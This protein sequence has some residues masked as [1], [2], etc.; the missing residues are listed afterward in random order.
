MQSLPG[1]GRSLAA[2]R[3]HDQQRGGGP[4]AFPAPLG[5]EGRGAEPQLPV[6]GRQDRA[7]RE[8]ALVGDLRGPTARKPRA[9]VVHG[10][11]AVPVED[12]RLLIEAL[13]AVVEP[14][15][16]RDAEAVHAHHIHA[17]RLHPARQA[18]DAPVEGLAGGEPD[19]VEE[20][21]VVLRGV[22]PPRRGHEGLA[23][24]PAGHGGEP[25]VRLVAALLLANLQ[26]GHRD[27]LVVAGG[28]QAQL[29]RR[30]APGPGERDPLLH[31]PV[32]PGLRLLRQ[33]VV[34][35]EAAHAVGDEDHAG[36]V[37]GSR[38]VFDELLQTPDVPGPLR[39]RGRVAEVVGGPPQA[40][41][42]RVPRP[43]EAQDHVAER[44][45]AVERDT[46]VQLLEG[47]GAAEVRHPS[48]D[49]VVVSELLRALVVHEPDV[50]RPAPGAG[51]QARRVQ[52][53]PEPVGL[54]LAVPGDGLRLVQAGLQL[55]RA[56]AG[57]NDDGLQACAATSRGKA[58]T[59]G[60][61][62]AI[63]APTA[64]G[65]ART[66]GKLG[67]LGVRPGPE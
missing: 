30:T 57:D 21:A 47:R 28:V 63:S 23:A 55:V 19:V 16:G 2:R 10:A 17:R 36:A 59:A 61:N 42:A 66:A 56:I 3:S 62:G 58:R 60:K 38:G 27:A 40:R 67:T 49:A 15:R 34:D 37:I 41:V 14:Q 48:L 31:E 64:G 44:G 46:R 8:E 5:A 26:R 24:E 12:A 45:G 7:V 54:P 13:A 33:E 52:P 32:L 50:V 29:L 65:H 20:R 1:L 25:K 11:I 51:E 4:A 22:V 18:L 39:R 43:D 9:D 53:E 6:Y 35:L